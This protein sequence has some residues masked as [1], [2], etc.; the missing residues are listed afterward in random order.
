LSQPEVIRNLRI[1]VDGPTYEALQATAA[2]NVMPVSVVASILIRQGIRAS[3]EAG[4]TVE[5]PRA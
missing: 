3:Q 1:R 5:V 2:V 4:L